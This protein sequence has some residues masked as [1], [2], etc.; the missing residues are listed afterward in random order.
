MVQST[1]GSRDKKLYAFNPDGNV[2]W[3]FETGDAIESSP[4]I[5]ADG[6]I[7]IG[8]NDGKLYA[9]GEAPGNK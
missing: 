8:S 1:S 2:K 4:T 7:Y 9:I 5:D 6:T 3:I